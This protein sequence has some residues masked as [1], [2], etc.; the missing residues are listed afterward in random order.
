MKLYG[1]L[2]PVKN[3]Y[4]VSLER[5]V[6][7]GSYNEVVNHHLETCTAA[8]IRRHVDGGKKENTAKGMKETLVKY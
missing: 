1:V 6:N 3:K 7:I 4:I 2:V 8:A 5:I